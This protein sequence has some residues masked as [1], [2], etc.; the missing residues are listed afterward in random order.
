MNLTE[1]QKAWMSGEAGPS[2]KWAMEF[3]HGLGAFF[4]AEEM[5]PVSSAHFAPDVRAGGEP[6]LRLLRTLADEGARTAVPG[7]LDPCMVDFTRE[8]EWISEYG[9]AEGKIA[10]ERELQILCMKLGFRPTYTCINYQSVQPPRF[11]EHLAWGD[12][13][14]AVCANA[15]FGARTNFEGGPSALASALTGCSPAYGMHRDE[16]RR[17]TLLIRLDCA[18]KEIAD[19]GAVARWSGQLAT[20][21]ETVPTFHGDFAPPDFDM[22]KQLGVALASYGGHAMFHVVGSTPEAGTLDQALGGRP[23]VDAHVMTQ[24]DLDSVFDSTGL[25]SDDVDLVVFSAPQLS[26]D[27]VRT[28]AHRLQGRRVHEATKVI[29]AVDPQVR[30][31]ADAEGISKTLQAAGAEYTT[32]TCFYPEAPWLTENSNW[33]N[34]VTNSAKLV[35]TVASVGIEGALR[36]LDVCIDAAV[37]GKLA[38]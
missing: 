15:L 5:V 38:A 16:N 25:P 28:L 37:T 3:N 4:G 36:R 2:M 30:M 23:G 27:E 32:G 19:W 17:G 26:I 22:L 12:T 9:L 18:P 6:C 1:Q 10:Q 33:R 34:M 7:T 8:A 31:Q 29:V 11:G 24:A 21:Y 20:G 13:G 35:N 14:A